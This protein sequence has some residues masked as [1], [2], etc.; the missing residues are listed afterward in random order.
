MVWGSQGRVRSDSCTKALS[1]HCSN[2]FLFA[3]E[4]IIWYENKRQKKTQKDRPQW[5]LVKAKNEVKPSTTGVSYQIVINNADI[6][7]LLPWNDQ[8]K[9]ICKLGV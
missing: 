4:H 7:D 2:G 9:E 6:E 5:H 8:V 3:R 1:F